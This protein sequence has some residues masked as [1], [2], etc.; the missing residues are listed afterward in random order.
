ML[1]FYKQLI[2]LYF[3]LDEK[4]NSYVYVVIGNCIHASKAQIPPY[5][6]KAYFSVFLKFQSLGLVILLVL[7][8]K[9]SWLLQDYVLLTSFCPVCLDF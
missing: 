5:N 4:S 7:V 9:S 3:I 1:A 8:S 2:F 6:I